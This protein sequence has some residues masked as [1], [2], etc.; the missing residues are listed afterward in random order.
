METFLLFVVV[1]VL[2]S[3]SPGERPSVQSSDPKSVLTAILFLYHDTEGGVQLYPLLQ[4][5]T[6]ATIP[7]AYDRVVFYPTQKIMSKALI[8]DTRGKGPKIMHK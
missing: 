4:A 7:P 6:M 1:N 2:L 5:N 3:L 8:S